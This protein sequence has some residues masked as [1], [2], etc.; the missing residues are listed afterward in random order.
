V[1]CQDGRAYLEDM[2]SGNGTFVN[3]QRVDG[4]TEL[5]HGDRIKLGPILLRFESDAPPPTRR[6]DDMTAS[7]GGSD[8]S[9]MSTPHGGLTGEF[10]DR[11]GGRSGEEADDF[12]PD[13]EVGST[14]VGSVETG[15]GFGLL[16]VQPEKKLRA[17]VELTKTLAGTVEP[18]QMLP[19]ILGT[20]FE[21]FPHADRGSIL[22]KDPHTGKIYPA[23]QRHRRAGEDASVRLSRTVLNKVLAEKTGILSADAAN[24]AQFQASESIANLSIHSIMCV[25]MLGLDHQVIGVINIDTQNPL[26]RFRREDLDLLQ[27]IAGQ[28]AVSFETARLYQSYLAKVKQDSELEIARHV[29]RALLPEKLPK[30]D[31]WQFFASYESAQA[32]GGDYYDAFMIDEDKVC[33]SFGDVAGKGVPGALI[34]SRIASCVQNTVPLIPDVERAFAA[35][36]NHMCRSMVE[37]RFVTYVLTI[38]DLKKCEMSLVNA[39]HMPP[40][41]RRP[42]G[43][44]DTFDEDTVGIPIGITTDY[45]YEVVRRK[46]EPGE[47]VVIVTDGVDEAMNPDGELYTK[48][49][50]FEFVRNA[51]PRAAELG[52]ALLADV[53]R[54]AA[55]RP[56]NDDITIMTFGRDPR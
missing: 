30:V 34:M 33:L 24:D 47:T 39:G 6:P 42:D 29:Q 9:T 20:L 48:A 46:I 28:S 1:V 37:G 56:Q 25:P 44:V 11:S 53:R 55:G 21:V 26:Q 19:M 36:N 7:L 31:G 10:G 13:E 3:G 43:S 35:I 2:Q 17:V 38:I 49:R 23:C 8:H 18:Q 16:D 4:R 40:L 27:A 45:P 32:V 15:G 14:I 51:S 41:I 52:E 12:Q 22:L 5:R 54:H 50:V